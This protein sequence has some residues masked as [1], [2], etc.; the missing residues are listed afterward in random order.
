MLLVLVSYIVIWRCCDKKNNSNHQFIIELSPSICLLL[1]MLAAT[2][3]GAVRSCHGILKQ[4]YGAST[5]FVSLY[6]TGTS[7]LNLTDPLAPQ[8]ER[9]RDT[10]IPMLT[11]FSRVSTLR[12]RLSNR[13]NGLLLLIF[14]LNIPLI[15]VDLSICIS[16]QRYKDVHGISLEQN[17]EVGIEDLA[18]DVSLKILK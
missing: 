4:G 11:P 17:I 9:A 1:G 13:S 14:M 5:I 3:I 10:S 8:A 15:A 18:Y 7:T 2:T 16:E 6:Q 12:L